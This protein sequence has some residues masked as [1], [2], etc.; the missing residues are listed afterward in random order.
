MKLE[1]KQSG[2]AQKR[3]GKKRQTK[4]SQRKRNVTYIKINIEASDYSA[5]QLNSK[6]MKSNISESNMP[7][8]ANQADCVQFIYQSAMWRCSQTKKKVVVIKESN[9]R[10][11]S[12]GSL[13]Y[14]FYKMT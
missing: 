7:M 13:D 10:G 8:K 3:G 1:R 6:L 14:L 9:H 2:S 12:S 11:R 4:E 5:A